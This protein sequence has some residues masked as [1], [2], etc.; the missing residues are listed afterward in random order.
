MI[1]DSRTQ[2]AAAAS[3]STAGT[4]LAVF[5]T[6]AGVVVDTRAGSGQAFAAFDRD[7]GGGG[8]GNTIYL[9]IQ[10]T[11]AVTSAG[12]ATLGFLLVSDAQDPVAVDGS[13]S[14]HAQTNLIPKASLVAGYTFIVP[15]PPQGSV[16]YE[17]YLAVIQNVGV[18]ALTAGKVNAFLAMN[19]KSWKA[20][21]DAI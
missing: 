17:R 3:L 8:D 9:M 12:A 1:E 19:V 6:G 13:A 2:F 5:P 7:I 21:P 20:Y 16:P 18:A 14:V 4:G 11:I 10:V 15:I